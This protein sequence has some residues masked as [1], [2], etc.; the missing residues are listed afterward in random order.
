MMKVLILR[1]KMLMVRVDNFRLRRQL[2]KMQ[3]QKN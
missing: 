3:P 2:K 1:V